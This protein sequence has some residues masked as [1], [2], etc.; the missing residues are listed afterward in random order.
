MMSNCNL[1]EW[2]T[3]GKKLPA[4]E[5]LGGTLMVNSCFFQRP[6]PHIVLGED[7]DS[8]VISANR[9]RGSAMIINHTKGNVQIGLNAENATPVE[10]PNAIVVDDDDAPPAFQTE[11]PW[12]TGA[13][14]DD[15][16]DF[17]HWA[18]RG[19][20][21]AFARWQAMVPN[22]DN[23]LVYVWYGGDPAND[24]ATNAVYSVKHS[25]GTTTVSVNL[26]EGWGKWRLLGKFR[27][28][29]SNPAI[30]RT[31]NAA[32]GNVL[33]DAVKLVPSSV[34]PGTPSRAGLRR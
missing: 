4:L 23:Y 32:N 34:A 20:G 13:G 11:G 25:D 29:T 14:I 33:A 1:M 3:G 15:Y 24:H 22:T 10:E 18:E 28:S 31:S 7:V 12:N 16:R 17:T 21:E 26:K 8:A 19:A 30:I 2:G 5:C 27:F 6:G 9:F